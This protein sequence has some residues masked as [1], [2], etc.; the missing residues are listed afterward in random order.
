LL[1][2]AARAATSV[3][4]AGKN[5]S[6]DASH[7]IGRAHNPPVKRGRL[8]VPP[9]GLPAPEGG[10]RHHVP[11][12]PP[13]GGV[14]ARAPQCPTPERQAVPAPYACV[15]QALPG[16]GL[17][18]R[19]RGRGYPYPDAYLCPMPAPHPGQGGRKAA[20]PPRGR[21]SPRHTARHVH[22][23][24]GARRREARFAV[25]AQVAPKVRHAV[26]NCASYARQVV[27]VLYVAMPRS[28]ARPVSP[29]SSSARMRLQMPHRKAA[30]WWQISRRKAART[31]ESD[32]VLTARSG[33]TVTIATTLITA[34]LGLGGSLIT[35]SISRDNNLDQLAAENQRSANE[36]LRK[37]RQD[38]YTAFGSELNAT[39]SAMVNINSQ[40]DPS[41]PP[42]LEDFDKADSDATS[43]FQKLNGSDLNVELVASQ[44]VCVVAENGRYRLFD[45]YKQHI[46]PAWPYVTR[47]KPADD[48][49]RKLQMTQEKIDELR[50]LFNDFIAAARE[51]LSGTD[52]RQPAKHCP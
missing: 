24:Y 45:A 18:P 15:P 43:H 20:T 7:R 17:Y 16:P 23:V 14:P 27:T 22:V 5:P 21:A 19:P 8:G 51:D 2:A 28:V 50:G 6:G 3:S 29:R 12:A 47:R 31:H 37:E 26:F 9:W 11:H 52:L 10:P 34:L 35:A 38:A 1:V 46:D 13:Q 40:I 48:E 39:F 49:Y 32:V 36:S 30:K 4:W 33:H 42:T 25:L 41:M 44:G